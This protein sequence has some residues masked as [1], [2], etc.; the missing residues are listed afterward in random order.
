MTQFECN[1]LKSP[2]C[3][4]QVVS[5]NHISSSDVPT[6]T[7]SPETTTDFFAD[8]TTTEDYFS[9][10][11][12]DNITENATV[13]EATDASLNI[14]VTTTEKDTV[15][16]D[17]ELYVSVGEESTPPEPTQTTTPVYNTASILSQPWLLILLPISMGLMCPPYFC[18][19]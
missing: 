16:V 2:S 8:N 12:D 5:T 19:R 3:L 9:S 1:F 13:T 10:T 15:S 7:I 4:L 17:T 18:F 11:E 6:T 14:T